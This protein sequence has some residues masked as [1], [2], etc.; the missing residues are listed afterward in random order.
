MII[1]KYLWLGFMLPIRNSL[2][3]RPD[4]NMRASQLS[5]SYLW[6]DL[7]EKIPHL[8]PLAALLDQ[9]KHVTNEK[10]PSRGVPLLAP[11]HRL[12]SCYEKQKSIYKLAFRLPIRDSLMTHPNLNMRAS[13]LSC[14]SLWTD[15]QKT[16]H[17]LALWEPC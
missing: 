13:E 7:Q 6:T 5:C 3:T 14:S 9:Q 10:R 15:L 8:G 17:T 12:I 4:L 16:Y 11:P 2:I 1:N